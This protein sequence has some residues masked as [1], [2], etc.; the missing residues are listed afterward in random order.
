MFRPPLE[1]SLVRETSFPLVI[2]ALVSIGYMAITKVEVGEGLQLFKPL[3]YVF[4]QF[5]IL[6]GYAVCTTVPVP[7]CINRNRRGSDFSGTANF[8]IAAAL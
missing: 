5:R 1:N 8:K 7:V 4:V 2:G 6:V 3:G